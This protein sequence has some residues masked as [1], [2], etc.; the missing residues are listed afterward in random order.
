[1]RIIYVANHGGRGN[2]EEGAITYALTKLG[3]TVLRLREPKGR[4]AVRLQGDMVLFHKW[5]DVNTLQVFGERGVVR[6]FWY[7]DLV[8]YPDETLRGR[9]Q[10]RMNWM[11][12]VLPHTDLGFCTDGDWVNRDKTGKLIH[13]PQGADSRYAGTPQWN[14]LGGKSIDI[15]FTGIRHGGQER[16]SFVAEM[17]SIYGDRFLQVSSGIHGRDLGNLIASAKIVVA[18]DGPITNNYW[19]NRVFLTLGYGGF[20]LH[21]Y[22]AGLE[23][24]YEDREEIVYYYSRE[25]LHNLINY[26]LNHPIERHTIAKVGWKRTLCEHTYL[27][28][29]KK[30][31]EIVQTRFPQCQK[32]S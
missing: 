13:L 2:D 25:H 14:P 10:A 15:L 7:F 17:S 12:R 9:C 21:P 6:V 30:L 1:M 19:S 8:D 22:C 11:E 18:P 26:Y 3:H 31:L 29:C 27:Q 4:R 5:D 28:R 16:Q 32:T 20:L 23:E 24:Y